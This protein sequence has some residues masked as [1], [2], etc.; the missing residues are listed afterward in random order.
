[1]IKGNI[2]GSGERIYHTPW[3]SDYG[4]TKIDEA[5]GERWFCDEAEAVA[6]GWRASRSR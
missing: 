2:S 3:S 4:R 5:K 1:P 6:E